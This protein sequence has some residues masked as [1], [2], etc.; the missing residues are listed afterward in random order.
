MNY[1]E[2]WKG[3]NIPKLHRE[4]DGSTFYMIPV[5]EC[6]LQYDE[7]TIDSL[8]PSEESYGWGGLTDTIVWANNAY[9]Y[10][11]FIPEFSRY[12]CIPR[13]FP[14]EDDAGQQLTEQGQVDRFL[15]LVDLAY[16][17]LPEDHLKVSPRSLAEAIL[18]LCD[19]MGEYIDTE[20][21]EKMDWEKR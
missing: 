9:K 16:G 8:L 6:F 3:Q 20:I 14:T 15:Y 5:M 2:K 11:Y 18:E 17:G 19:N 21:I 4:Y 1:V 7:D 13:W 12:G 10:I